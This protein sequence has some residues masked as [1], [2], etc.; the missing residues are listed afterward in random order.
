MTIHAFLMYFHVS[1]G[2]PKIPVAFTLTA[3]GISSSHLVWQRVARYFK[4]EMFLERVPLSKTH[5]RADDS[6][7]H[8]IFF[9]H[10]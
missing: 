8:L 7:R 3:L 9:P 6:S 5:R 4:I 1:F 10:W 2:T